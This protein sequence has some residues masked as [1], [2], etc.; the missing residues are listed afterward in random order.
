[1]GAFKLLS[2]QQDTMTRSYKV[3]DMIFTSVRQT[4]LC[5]CKNVNLRSVI[6]RINL[7]CK[8]IRN[9]NGLDPNWQEISYLH[10][11]NKKTDYAMLNSC[12]LPVIDSSY[13]YDF[14]Q[15]NL[16]GK[17]LQIFVWRVLRIR[18]K[19]TTATVYH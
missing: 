16:S 19:N 3:Y 6:E 17:Y 2:H 10:S 4:I 15:W 8:P 12:G 9:D 18:S 14:T 5:S 13:V 1:M 11:T 7:N